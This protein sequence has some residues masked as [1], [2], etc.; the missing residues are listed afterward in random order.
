MD[1]S[2]VHLAVTLQVPGGYLSPYLLFGLKKH[3]PGAFRH[4]VGCL[5]GKG[6]CQ[7]GVDCPCRTTFSQELSADPSQ[8]RRH[9]KPPLPFLFEIPLLQG[10]PGG[11]R[12]V[13]VVLRLI[14]SAATSLVEIYLQ[15]LLQLFGDN[16]SFLPKGAK[17]V[18]VEALSPD[19]GSSYL[20][21]PS[22]S[23][24]LSVI[25]VA[26]FDELLAAP[27]GNVSDI[28]LVFTTPA[29]ILAAGRPLRELP[30]SAVAGAL[31]RRIS[32]LA[33]YYGGVELDH[34]FKWLAEQSRVVR[35]SSAALSWADWGGG[36]QG[37]TGEVSYRG[38]LTQ[39]LPFLK[40][41]ELLHVGK[42]ASYGMG[43]YEI[44]AL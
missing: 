41:G 21:G 6:G 37:I 44:T 40:L 33:S 43:Q 32:S 15:S 8:L 9:Q 17:L 13:V 29:R 22:G 25:P 18:R 31:L 10:Q 24:D 23:F 42:G 4:A 3:F 20:G 34:D 36:V 19:G 38:E 11:M 35:C 12:E 27:S 30:F 26:S 16:S 14:G 39:F 5:D 2:L 1:T 7:A 28:S